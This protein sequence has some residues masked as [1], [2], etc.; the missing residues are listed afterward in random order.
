MEPKDDQSRVLTDLAAC[1]EVLDGRLDLALAFKDYRAAKGVRVGTTAGHA[2]TAPYK[3][4][5]PGVPHVCAKVLSASGKTFVAVNALATVFSAL[6]KRSPRRPRRPRL[7]VWRVLS[8]TIF[9]QT[10][11]TLGS[12]EHP[13][14]QRLDQ[15]FQH[16]VAGF[17]TRDLLTGAGFSQD[18]AAA[19]LHPGAQRGLLRG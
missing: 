10:V 15:L 17:E 8:L 3:I 1:R 9:D 12:P 7:V 2:G 14:G 16:R 5:V 11:R 6:A 13:Y 4:T 18:A 19:A